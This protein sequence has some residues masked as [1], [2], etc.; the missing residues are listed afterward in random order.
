MAYVKGRVLDIGCGAGRFMLHLKAHGHEVTGI[1]ISPGAIEVCRLRGLGDVHVMS[2]SQ[3]SPRLG[4]FDT[5][6]MLGGNL[7]LLGDG[8][9]GRRVLARLHRVAQTGAI[10]LGASRDRTQTG[11]PAMQEYVSR[12]LAA[13]RLSGYAR[14]RIRYKKFATPFAEY[15]RI[16]VAELRS[17]IEGTG[18]RLGEVIDRGEGIYI[19]VLE[20]T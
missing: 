15:L 13:G 18:W 6:L 4:M 7:G 19:G 10:L 8:D 2:V 20:R 5:L 17:V 9:H 14:N 12:N 16:T 1:D 3:V 11:D